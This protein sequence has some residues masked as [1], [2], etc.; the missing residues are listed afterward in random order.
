[1]LSTFADLCFKIYLFEKKTSCRNTIRVSNN[2]DP[3][4]AQSYVTNCLQMFSV[5]D[6]WP[7]AGETLTV[8]RASEQPAHP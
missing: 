7:L 5:D 1:M 6:K 2:L 4:P 8:N 3:D